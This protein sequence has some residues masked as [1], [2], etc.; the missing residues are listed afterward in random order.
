MSVFARRSQVIPE[1]RRE[2]VSDPFLDNG[3]D[4]SESGMPN[5]PMVVLELDDLCDAPAETIARTAGHIED[6]LAL[7][8]GVLNRP[9]SRAMGPVLAATTLTLTELPVAD[10][11]HQVISVEET[12][13]ALATLGAAVARSPRAA[14]ACGQLL[15]QTSKLD[16]MQA[17]A[18]EA[19]VY[20]MLLAGPE[21]ARWL[22]ERGPA[23][24]KPPAADTLVRLHR[25]DGHLSIVLDHPQRRNALSVRLRE[26]LLA[27]AQVAAADSSITSVELSGTG[28]DF[29]SGGDLDEFGCATDLVAS[30][31]V[32]LDRAPW[33]VFD[34]IAGHLVARVTGACIGAGA[35]IAAMAGTV[36]AAP[37]TY[38]SFPEVH[39]GL[40]PG[41]GGTVSVP[42]RIGRW[43]AAWLMLTG[44]RLPV[45]TA[46]R[47]GLVDRMTEARN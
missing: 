9:P 18:A 46:L 12:D 1:N 36:A 29:C 3:L 44:Q 2:M 26:E 19:A 15:R 35:E 25:T 31:L 6:S 34:R 30:Y 20:S 32:R 43:R 45:P 27:A 38:F 40:V 28:P 4:L 22:T 24:P 10:L 21:F 41:A 5:R 16:T 7:V 14:L 33:R 23:R 42:S 11:L 37:D 8:I 13:V 17:L 47:W 39:M